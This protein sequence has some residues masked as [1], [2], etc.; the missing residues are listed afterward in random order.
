LQLQY[1]EAGHRTENKKAVP[2]SNKIVHYR[3]NYYSR[4]ATEDIA[5]LKNWRNTLKELIYSHSFLSRYKTVVFLR[6]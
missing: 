4:V 2:S 1:L 3:I 5:A 6:I